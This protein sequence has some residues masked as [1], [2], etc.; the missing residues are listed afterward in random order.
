VR[1]QTVP[2]NHKD[3][4]ILANRLLKGLGIDLFDEDGFADYEKIEALVKLVDDFVKG[5]M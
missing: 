1:S 4:V 5:R 2:A 3:R